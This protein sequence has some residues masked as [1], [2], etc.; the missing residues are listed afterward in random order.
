MIETIGKEEVADALRISVATARDKVM[1]RPG[2]PRPVNPWGKEK[3]II[4]AD[5]EKWL[6][7]QTQS[8]LDARSETDAA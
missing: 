8:S 2:F 6:I 5:F 7:A 4:K 1:K 3:R